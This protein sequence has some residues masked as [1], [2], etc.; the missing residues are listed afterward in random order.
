MLLFLVLLTSIAQSARAAGCSDEGEA[1]H[2]HRDCLKIG[3]QKAN[4]ALCLHLRFPAKRLLCKVADMTDFEGIE[5]H[6]LDDRE[7]DECAAAGEDAH[8]C[9]LRHARADAVVYVL[10]LGDHASFLRTAGERQEALAEYMD[11]STVLV[12]G[13]SPVDSL[14]PALMKQL[15]CPRGTLSGEPL[16]GLQHLT[17]C[18]E[19]SIAKL[20]Y[21]P[22]GSHARFHTIQGM[23]PL[24][25]ILGDMAV[26]RD[27]VERLVLIVDFPVAHMQTG[28]MIHEQHD[29]VE[30][31]VVG[32]ASIIADVAGGAA[33]EALLGRG[34]NVTDVIVLE[35]LPQH[36]PLED[37]AY[38][39]DALAA[40]GDAQQNLTCRGPLP[41]GC[42]LGTLAEMQRRAFSAAEGFA[43]ENYLRTFGFSN[44]FWWTHRG[45]GRTGL[46]CT[47]WEGG[48]NTFV[49]LVL[50]AWFHARQG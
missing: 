11:G 23:T 24:A 25:E 18:G 46:D 34:I 6:L 10:T 20:N 49:G 43:P 3:P 28:P 42:A 16:P 31:N 39:R 5:E 15:D 17:P 12:V 36:F 41:E 1:H 35:G 13:A 27:R 32:F 50:Q 33:R 47:H 37:F 48:P 19:G 14:M 44:L 30:E 26:R 40:M 4:Q 45:W 7:I 2:Y 21:Y 29:I 8:A 38:D 22:V 9:L